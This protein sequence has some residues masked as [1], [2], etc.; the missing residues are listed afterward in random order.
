MHYAWQRLTAGD[1]MASP[2]HRDPPAGTTNALATMPR[3]AWPRRR[4]VDRGEDH[5]RVSRQSRDGRDSHLG[6]VLLFDASN[7]SPRHR[8]RVVDHRDPHCRG[9][10]ARNAPDRNDQRASSPCSAPAR[11]RC[12]ISTPSGRAPIRHVRIWSG[13]ARRPRLCRA[14]GRARAAGEHDITVTVCDSAE[15]AVRGAHVV[16]TIT[17]ARQPV[18]EG[19]C[20]RLGTHVN[21]VG[22]SVPGAELDSAAFRARGCTWTAAIRARG[23]WRF[24]R[25][26]V[27][28]A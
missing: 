1:S 17:S 10:G 5:H 28:G 3:G 11:L 2:A 26:E 14:R 6:V 4:R 19:A 18:L 25:A 23:V 12:R 22:A 9:V 20:S 16:C 21:A 27:G 13:P 7:G 24:P 15:E 8:G